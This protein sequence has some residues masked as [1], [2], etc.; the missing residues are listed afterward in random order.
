MERN[1]FARKIHLISNRKNKPFI[2]IKWCFI[3]SEKYEK[4]LF[5]EELADGSIIYGAFR[6]IIRWNIIN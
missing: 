6:K 3:N 1:L 2:I 4:E 5:G